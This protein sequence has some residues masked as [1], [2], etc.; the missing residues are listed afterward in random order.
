MSWSSCCFLVNTDTIHPVLF[1]LF[2]WF[3]CFILVAQC[4][5]FIILILFGSF[6]LL[7]TIVIILSLVLFLGLQCVFSRISGSKEPT[8]IYSEISPTEFLFHVSMHQILV[9]LLWTLDLPSHWGR[10]S[11]WVVGGHEYYL[12]ARAQVYQVYW[13]PWLRFAGQVNLVSHLD[14]KPWTICW[15]NSTS[16]RPGLSV[17]YTYLS[18]LMFSV[19]MESTSLNIHLFSSPSFELHIHTCSCSWNRTMIA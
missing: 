10:A 5:F 17:C 13:P 3:F 12:N 16:S 4:C 19:W 8:H 18:F 2:I 9:L 1:L 15:L 6:T 11:V 14:L 7:S